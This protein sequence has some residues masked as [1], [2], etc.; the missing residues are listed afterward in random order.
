MTSAYRSKPKRK[1]NFAG[2]LYRQI[3]GQKIYQ[4]DCSEILKNFADRS[5]LQFITSPPYN[6]GIKYHSYKDNKTGEDY[7][8]WIYDIFTEVK[9]VLVDDGSL[10]LVIGG[11]NVK[12][13]IPTDVRR[14][15][16]GLFELQNDI[17]W[18]KS[19]SIEDES[20][21][22]FKPINSYRFLNNNYEHI[23]HFTKTGYVP[24][25]RLSIGV[26]YTDKNNLKRKKDPID[27]RCGGNVWFIPYETINSKDQKGD[28]PA[29]FPRELVE[30]CIRLHG[31]DKDTIVCDPFM[32]SGTTLVVAKQLD[33]KGVGIEL[34]EKYFE[35]SY[36][37]L[38]GMKKY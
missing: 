33:I 24:I 23:F 37:Q 31:Y 30:R 5:I 3:D 8:E 7:L 25:D 11:T 32:G 10:F 34:D 20:Y 17:I 29:I 12:P 19:I 6:I 21:G 28:H 35:Y 36:N 22:H 2:K 9:R 1:D 27:K 15:L 38:K 4:G 16:K 14:K 18:V 26:P 13:D